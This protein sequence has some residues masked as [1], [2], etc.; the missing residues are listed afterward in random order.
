MYSL[1]SLPYLSNELGRMGAESFM[2][3]D[4]F[5]CQ[6]AFD[7]LDTEFVAHHDDHHDAVL[8]LR[9][10]RGLRNLELASPKDMDAI[11]RAMFNPSW[12]K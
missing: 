9:A 1:S 11:E 4:D 3:G 2:Q 12:R 10:I 7:L 5:L 8:D 6:M